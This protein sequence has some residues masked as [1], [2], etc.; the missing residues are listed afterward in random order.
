VSLDTTVASEPRPVAPEPEFSVLGVSVRRHAALPAL[1][2][3]VHVTEPTGRHVYVIALSVQI[4]IEPARRQYD[5]GERTRLVELFGPVERWATTTRSLVLHRAD[6]LVGEFSGSTTFRV[7]VPCTFDLEIAAAKYFDAVVGGEVPLAF[8]FN[9]TVHHRGDD[10]RLQ[11]SLVPWS[12][13][14]EYRFPAEVW[15][16]AM[17]EHFPNTRWIAV[18]EGTLR[19]LLADKARRGAPTMDAAV[20]ALLEDAGA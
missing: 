7:S 15:R 20:A 14:T 12:C 10:G 8:N 3:D 13:S 1:D 4:M 16:E 11:L 17:E 18:H 19:A 9:G 6:V 5:E 2:F